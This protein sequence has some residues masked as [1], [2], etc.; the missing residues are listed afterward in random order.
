V[1]A[2]RVG[3][4]V[5][6]VTKIGGDAFGDIA[7]ATWRREGIAAQ[8]VRAEAEATGAAFIYVNDKT[9]ENAIII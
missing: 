4:K 6:F 1:A 2:A 8:V 7:L 3:A 5:T 9:G